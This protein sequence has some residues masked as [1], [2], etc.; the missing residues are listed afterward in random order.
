MQQHI[1][2]WPIPVTLLRGLISISVRV[3]VSLKKAHPILVTLLRGVRLM[4][5]RDVQ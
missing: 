4:V 5:W 1:N 2:P 3:D